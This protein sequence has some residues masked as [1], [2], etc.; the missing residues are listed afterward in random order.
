M[1]EKKDLMDVQQKEMIVQTVTQGKWWRWS[2]YG[3]ALAIIPGMFLAILTGQF[4]FVA[5]PLTLSLWLN[6]FRRGYGDRNTLQILLI[7][8]Q[9]LFNRYESVLESTRRDR[10]ELLINHAGELPERDY[11]QLMRVLEFRMECIEKNRDS[12][13]AFLEESFQGVESA[14]QEIQGL[15]AAQDRSLED[16]TQSL[17]SQGS[18]ILSPQ[19]IHDRIQRLSDQFEASERFFT[20]HHQIFV[21][22]LDARLRILEESLSEREIQGTEIADDPKFIEQ[23]SAVERPLRTRLDDLN[24]KFLAVSEERLISDRSPIFE[25]ET[26]LDGMHL[27]LTGQLNEWEEL[28]QDQGYKFQRLNERLMALRQ[29]LEKTYQVLLEHSVGIEQ[30]LIPSQFFALDFSDSNP[31]EDLDVEAIKGRLDAIRTQL[32]NLGNIPRRMTLILN[33]R[34]EVASEQVEQMFG[35]VADAFNLPDEGQFNMLL[36]PLLQHYSDCDE[37]LSQMTHASSVTDLEEALLGLESQIRFLSQRLESI[38]GLS[39]EKLDPYNNLLVKLS[40]IRYRAEELKSQVVIE[41]EQIPFVID[42]YLRQKYPP[43]K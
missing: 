36:T 17:D 22:D 2:E 3:S 38:E 26:Q 20:P 1:L 19:E 42:N 7:E 28:H 27:A 37:R 25:L 15:Q 10:A 8:Q 40:T 5:T 43:R 23:W 4:A 21:Q 13:Q 39:A 30:M 11:P 18:L 34:L 41:L 16:V 9:G 29:T 35:R 6:L 24:M 31:L 12:L 33:Q 32:E 14:I